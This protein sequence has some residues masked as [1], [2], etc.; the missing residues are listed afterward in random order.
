MCNIDIL[1]FVST[2]VS[3]AIQ[4]ARNLIPDMLN[5][6]SINICIYTYRYTDKPTC[7]QLQ[8]S[9]YFSQKNSQ[10]NCPKVKT[11]DRKP[12]N[13]HRKTT[14]GP[15]YIYSPNFSVAW[16]HDW[17]FRSVMGSYKAAHNDTSALG[18]SLV[19]TR[20]NKRLMKSRISSSFYKWSHND[21]VWIWPYLRLGTMR[22]KI[23]S[24][25]RWLMSLCI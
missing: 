2:D 18:M 4:L 12:S 25:S 15:M 24:I 19:V 20:Q 10:I 22:G 5:Q 13:L 14:S 17:C 6:A 9:Q 21:G 1:S 16:H 3:F 11:S 23:C 7:Y 8:A